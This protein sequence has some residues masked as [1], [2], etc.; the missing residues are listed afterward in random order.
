MLKFCY[1]IRLEIL[2][3]MYDNR[4]IVIISSCKLLVEGKFGK[5]R[6]SY[7][8]LVDVSLATICVNW[9][10]FLNVLLFTIECK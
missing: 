8:S 6:P 7:L 4:D 1:S 3:W 5:I 10:G 9:R 2:F